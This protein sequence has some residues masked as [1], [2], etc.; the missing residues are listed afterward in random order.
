MRRLHLDCLDVPLCTKGTRMQSA[1]WTI[2]TDSDA[3]VEF[4]TCANGARLSSPGSA[5]NTSTI[6][7]DGE[8][9]FFDSPHRGSL[10]LI[11]VCGTNARHSGHALVPKRHLTSDVFCTV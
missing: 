2:P 9:V 11:V 3:R 4:L 10:W 6:T 8:P 7:A 1:S 5:I